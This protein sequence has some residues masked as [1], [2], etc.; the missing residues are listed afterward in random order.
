MAKS[1]VLEQILELLRPWQMPSFA[2]LDGQECPPYKERLIDG[3]SRSRRGRDAP[4]ASSGQALGTA[5]KMPARLIFGAVIIMRPWDYR[6]SRI[7]VTTE[8]R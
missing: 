1:Q 2:R 7:A 8:K 4:S 3:R 6:E 5:G